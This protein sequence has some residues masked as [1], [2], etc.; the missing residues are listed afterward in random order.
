M[1]LTALIKKLRERIPEITLRTTLITGFPGESP[2]QFCELC[3]FV[4]QMEFDRL[5][6]FAYSPEEDTAAAGF[7][8]QI[9]EQTKQ[10]RY[11]ALMQLQLDISASLQEEKIGSV[12]PVLCEG[13]DAVAKIYFGRSEADAP[14]VDGKIYFSSK[15]KLSEGEFVLVEI[16]EAM[17]YDLI[18]FALEK[19]RKA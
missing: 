16:T 3:E 5:G 17:D 9:D 6:C 12:L 14:D 18:G 7:E 1:T 2:A 10:D 8:G 19:A 11:D 4:N 13:Y 15:R